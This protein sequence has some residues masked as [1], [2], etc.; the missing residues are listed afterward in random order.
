MGRP[1]PLDM[2][3]QVMGLRRTGRSY[4]QIAAKL[5]L[6]RNTVYGIVKRYNDRGNLVPRKSTGHP[7][8]TT[9]RDDRA[10]V[11]IG[12]RNRRM[13]VPQLRMEWQ[14]HTNI[15]VSESTVTKRLKTSRY[16][17]RRVVKYPN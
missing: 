8:I 3:G 1:L 13:T 4:R 7:R 16:I 12:Q 17:A 15:R 10:L 14:R 5:N 6:H 11:R 9:P 2:A